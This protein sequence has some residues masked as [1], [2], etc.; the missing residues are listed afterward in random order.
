LS[1]LR[2][3]S[4]ITLFLSLFFIAYGQNEAQEYVDS[5]ISFDSLCQESI[6][7]VKAIDEDGNV[8]VS[9]NEKYP[10]QTASI[11]KT[12]TS[13]VAFDLLGPDYK[14]KTTIAYDGKIEEGTLFG[15]LY[16]VGG[17]DPT[18]GSKDSIAT[19]IEQ[20]F[21]TWAGAMVAAGISKIEGRII[22][23]ERF[24]DGESIP[25]NWVYG[26]LG[27][28]YGCSAHGLN[29][30]ENH[31][32]YYIKPGSVV[33]DPVLIEPGKYVIPGYEIINLTQTGDK[34]SGDKIEFYPSMN[35]EIGRFSGTYAVNGKGKTIEFTN[36]YASLTCA[37]EFSKFLSDRG[38]FADQITSSAISKDLKPQDE[39]TTIVETYS[40]SIERIIHSM[41]ASSNNLY[42]ESIYRVIGKEL[43][44]SSDYQAVNRAISDYIETYIC[45]VDGYKQSDGSGLSRN[46][47]ASP[48]FFC[49]FLSAAESLPYFERYFQCFPVAGREGTVKTLLPGYANRDKI[50]VKSGS[51]S[52][53]RCYCGYI[54]TGKGYT[55][56]SVMFN[57]FTGTSSTV[58]KK[59]EG[60]IEKIGM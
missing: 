20:L 56:F 52:L 51:M 49:R 7:G 44:G 38:I 53:V 31:S 55:K 15:D 40:P 34:G 17:G 8:L 10:L 1:Y 48:D 36:T 41:L 54:E 30:Y 25:I 37:F 39:L 14:F 18:L 33:G 13:A 42:A 57:N 16:I 26:D 60:I 5:L 6:I 50:H 59:I 2:K 58:V 24:F 11:M 12:V 4:L 46:N 22:G 47:I 29:F 43:C 45:D 21:S 27:F 3:L 28:N 19:A 35:S 32:E 9:Y 23:D